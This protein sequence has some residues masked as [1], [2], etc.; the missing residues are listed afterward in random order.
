MS[1]VKL[2][3]SPT[4]PPELRRPVE[5]IL[6]ALSPYFCRTVDELRINFHD[7]RDSAA[8]ITVQYS[9]RSATIGLSANFAT[10]SEADREH[11]LCHELSHIPLTPLYNVIDSMMEE[12][13]SEEARRMA[14]LWLEDALEGATEDVARAVLAAHRRQA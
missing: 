4:F 1:K 11:V 12:L 8:M 7:Q 6:R 5:R 14:K 9:Y 2:A 13:P 3:F 10:L